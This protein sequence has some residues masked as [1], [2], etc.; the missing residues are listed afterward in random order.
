[1]KPPFSGLIVAPVTPMLKN[2]DLNL[3]HVPRLASAFKRNGLSGAFIAGTTGEGMSLSQEER[4]ELAEAWRDS[5]NED[6]AL[7]V[8]VGHNSL[9]DSKALARH[10][11]KEVKADAIALV[12]PSYHKPGEMRDMADFIKQVSDEAPETPLYFYHIPGM[13]GFT[14]QMHKFIVL[15]EEEIPAFTGLKFSDD[16][17]MDYGLCLNSH[18]SRFNI[19][20]GRDENLLAGLSLGATGFVGATYNVA[21]PLYLKIIEAFREQN[22]DRARELQQQSRI[23]VNTLQ[24]Y[25]FIPALKA[26]MKFLKLDAGPLRPPQRSLR[27]DLVNALYADLHR[28]DFFSYSLKV[29]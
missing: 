12:P 29:E 25:G 15:L 2:G 13:S 19:L 22:M 20:F 3:D 11:A 14:F 10:A 9:A 16:D 1:M 27:E 24:K 5:V 28:I 21:A 7:I 17:L 4:K 8:H 23:L 6:F 26:T 18:N